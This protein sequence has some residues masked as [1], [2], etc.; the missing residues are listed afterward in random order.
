MGDTIAYPS[1]PVLPPISSIGSPLELLIEFVLQLGIPYLTRFCGLNR[2]TI[3]LVNSDHQYTA[4][5]E[6]CPNINHAIV[7]I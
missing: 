5:I 4:I 3:Q 2:Y 6:R 7:S 1:P